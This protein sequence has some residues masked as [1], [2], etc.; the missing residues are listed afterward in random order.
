[1]E[2]IVPHCTVFAPLL[3]IVW[4]YMQRFISGL[5]TVPLVY[6]SWPYDS[7]TVIIL[8]DSIIVCIFSLP[9]SLYFHIFF[10]WLFSILLLQLE[11]FPL[12]FLLGLVCWWWTLSSCLSEEVLITSFLKDSFATYNIFGW[13]VLFLFFSSLNV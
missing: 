5:S 7:T 9:E 3:K 4:P 6:I 10:L 8:Q 2:E 1:M 11:G 12:S 13:Q